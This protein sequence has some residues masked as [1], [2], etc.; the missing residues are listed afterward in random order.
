MRNVL[1]SLAV[2]IL[3]PGAG[4][5]MICSYQQWLCIGLEDRVEVVWLECAIYGIDSSASAFCTAAKNNFLTF[6]L[7]GIILCWTW[8]KPCHSFWTLSLG[9]HGTQQELWTKCFGLTE[10]TSAVTHKEEEMVCDVSGQISSVTQE[11][12]RSDLLEQNSYG[13]H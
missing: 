11:S 7:H 5:G 13:I 3:L 10:I 12:F 9:P 2:R 8:F 4:L 1:L 6:V